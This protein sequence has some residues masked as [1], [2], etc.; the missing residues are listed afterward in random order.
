MLEVCG[1]NRVL[2]DE[3]FIEFPRVMIFA[4]ALSRL[5]LGTIVCGNKKG[6]VR[7]RFDAGI[8][9]CVLFSWW[10]RDELISHSASLEQSV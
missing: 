4:A 3:R 8:V 6:S 7:E 10:R 5:D 1:G 9:C 2:L